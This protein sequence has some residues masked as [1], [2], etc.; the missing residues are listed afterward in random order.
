MDI[1]PAE[2]A[3]A[4]N[5]TTPSITHVFVVMLENHSFDNM[6]AMSDIEG[7]QAATTSDFNEH[8]GQ[9]YYV[10]RGA[11]VSMPTDP[12][13]E[14][15]DTL[16][17]LA[18]SQAT[19]PRGG[20]YPPIDN[21]GFAANYATSCSEHTGLPKKDQVGDVMA[22][23]D[24]AEQLPVL[25]RL[26]TEFAVCDHWFSSIPGPTW[27]NRFFVHGASSSGLDDT[28]K[29]LQIAEWEGGEGFTYA[30][31]S[32]FDALQA[33]CIPYRIYH[34]TSGFP[35]EESLY[36]DLPV[37][38]LLLGAI[39]QVGSIRGVSAWKMRSL[40]HFAS[41]LQG[42]Y[43]YAYTFIEPHYGDILF[44]TYA[45][46]SSQHPKDDVYGGEN[47]VAAVYEAIRNSPYWNNSLLIV[48]YDEH[49]GLYDSVAP[50]AAVPPGDTPPHDYGKFGFD[51][52]QYGV[53]VPAVV[54]SPWIAAGTVDPTVYDHASVLATLEKLF[55]LKPLTQRDAQASNVLGLLTL[56]EPR[57][58]CPT[59]LRRPSPSPQA[60]SA[61]TPEERALRA[62]EPV[63][64]ASNL[65]GALYALMKAD[66]ELSSGDPAEVAAIRARHAAIRTRGD[67][68]AY[69]ESVMP[70]VGMAREQ[71]E[72][73]SGGLP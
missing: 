68:R 55:S 47:L 24:T 70:K 39:P 58:D 31:G 23:F 36:A 69:A 12:G 66:V 40:K 49:G 3:P 54:V 17:Q 6:L 27:P 5:G 18:G 45:G 50:G 16:E 37:T 13:H 42:P 71:H 15:L 46:G 60:A 1:Q 9:R 2:P 61:P 72:K 21:S 41:D 8:L 30:N 73:A 29:G 11:P 22:C 62:A 44:E 63:P 34:D 33:A 7:I 32:I 53:R 28:P 67:A 4:G 43:P 52:G 35:R 10:Q 38:G 51:F 26:A 25:H 59:R 65:S 48:T 57:P 64:P 20:P 56:T 19:Y 14:F